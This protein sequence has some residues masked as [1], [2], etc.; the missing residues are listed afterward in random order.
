[1]KNLILTLGILAMTALAADPVAIKGQSSVFQGPLSWGTNTAT[2]RLIV[3]QAGAGRYKVAT[4]SGTYATL[5]TAANAPYTGAAGACT[6]EISLENSAAVS[7]EKNCIVH[8]TYR[9]SDTG[10]GGIRI[11]F[12]KRWA[13][14]AA[15]DSTYM[16]YQALWDSTAVIDTHTPLYRRSTSYS[17]DAKFG[18]QAA[19]AKVCVEATDIG[20]GD[21]VYV[22]LA[23][24]CF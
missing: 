4:N 11:K 1:M 13:G 12:Y 6:K 22:T 21:T 23:A 3:L 7:A 15:T 2:T 19:K 14:P 16:L 9:A 24:R 8:F 18:A 20:T 5:D 10:D 17:A